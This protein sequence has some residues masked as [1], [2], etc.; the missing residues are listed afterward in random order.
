MSS[1]FHPA[2]TA[3]RK[4]LKAAGIETFRRG[5]LSLQVLSREYRDR[6][7]IIDL[8]LNQQNDGEGRFIVC[9]LFDEHPDYEAAA[10]FNRQEFTWK[11]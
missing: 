4:I 11:A 9:W 10:P 2:Q 8:E 1:K 3:A 5:A 6:P 7:L